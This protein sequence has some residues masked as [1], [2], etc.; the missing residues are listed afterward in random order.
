MNLGLNILYLIFLLNFFIESFLFFFKFFSSDLHLLI[1]KLKLKS[2]FFG[3][4]ELYPIFV[5]FCMILKIFEVE[6][7]DIF[8]S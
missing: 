8:I 7:G 5:P 4:K 3:V 1:F 6:L 2:V